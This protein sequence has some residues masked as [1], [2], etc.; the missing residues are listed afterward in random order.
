MT[1]FIDKATGFVSKREAVKM[2]QIRYT[3]RIVND[4]EKINAFLERSRVG[5]VGMQ[6]A[7]YPYAVPVNYVMMNGCV[8]F[9]GM[10]SGKKVELLDQSPKVCFTVFEEVG[11]VSDNVP[12]HV[13]TAYMS[14]MIM[15]TA[16]R[17]TDSGEAA[18]ALQL[19]LDKFMPG[20]FNQKIGSTLVEKYRSGLDSNAVAVFKI[21]TEC[22]TAKENSA[23]PDALFQA[24][25]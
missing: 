14:V 12:C 16:K 8:Y 24:A 11:T 5:V 9:H 1:T 17:V 20:F 25:P 19:L 23:T 3:K 6:A 13:D 7:E 10:G 2:E 21:E 4:T 15:G 22:L 18:E